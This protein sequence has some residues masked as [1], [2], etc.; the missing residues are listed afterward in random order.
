MFHRKG[1]NQRRESGWEWPLKYEPIVRPKTANF[2]TLLLS[3]RR[4]TEGPG[5]ALDRSSPANLGSYRVGIE[6]KNGWMGWIGWS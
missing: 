5:H 3:W 1:G 4:L 2:S 6:Q